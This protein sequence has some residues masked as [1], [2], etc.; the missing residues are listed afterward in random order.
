MVSS[1]GSLG[2]PG[3]SLKVWKEYFPNAEIIGVDI[4]SDCLFKEER[5]KTFQIDQTNP[6]SIEEVLNKIKIEEFDLIVDDGLHTFEAGRILFE[7]LII[8]LANTGTYIIE[9]VNPWDVRKFEEYFENSIYAV[10][11]IHLI[12]KGTSL[13]DNSLVVIR[14]K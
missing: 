3:A 6:K 10:Y 14:K 13:A 4:D 8:R 9:D 7:N 11:F 2:K 12:R 1:M 5:I